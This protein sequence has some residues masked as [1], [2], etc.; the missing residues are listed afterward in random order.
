MSVKYSA[1]YEVTYYNYESG[2]E[3]SVLYTNLFIKAYLTVIKLEKDWYCVT[4]KFRR[5]HCFKR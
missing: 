1:K 4:L 5:N 2:K 3:V